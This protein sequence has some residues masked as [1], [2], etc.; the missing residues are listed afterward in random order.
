[1]R[2]KERRDGV[3]ERRLSEAQ[4]RGHRNGSGIFGTVLLLATGLIIQAVRTA[5][6]RP[7]ISKTNRL[8]RAGTRNVSNGQIALIIGDHVQNV[9]KS[10]RTYQHVDLGIDL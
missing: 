2:R 1:M 5:F 7:S 6:A 8:D 10:C 3:A 4:M 9:D